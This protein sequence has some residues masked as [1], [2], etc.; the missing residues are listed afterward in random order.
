MDIHAPHE[1]IHNWRDFALHLTIVTIGL[2][3]ALSLEALVEHI[4]N[5]HLVAEA[6]A[7]IRQELENNHEAAQQD[8]GYL[9]QYI[10]RSM[11]S[12]VTIHKLIADQKH[13]HGSLSY[14]MRFN[15]PSDA[16]WSTARD[17]GALGFMPYNEVQGYSDIYQEQKVVTDQSIEIFHRQTLAIAPALMYDGFGDIPPDQTEA[18]LHDTTAT[19]IE[20][21]VL[22][23]VVQQLDQQYVATLKQ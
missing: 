9:Q 20:L 17:T 21:T 14:T 11:A 5:R 15:S 6:R 10:D 22:K 23:Q 19:L 7:N 2:F 3:I 16:A 13:F 12:I 18:L 4:H 8:L 1:P